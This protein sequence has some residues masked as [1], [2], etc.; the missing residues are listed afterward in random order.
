MAGACT[1]G[2]APSCDDG[3]VCNGAE[4]CNPVDGTCLAGAPISC[5]VL[6]NNGLAPPIAS[7]L[8]DHVDYNEASGQLVYVRS[9]GC[10]PFGG[11]DS[12][13]CPIP[14]VPTTL[15]VAVGGD[16]GD[17]DVF[18]TALLQ[19]TGGS[20]Q[21]LASGQNAWVDLLGGA[22]ASAESYG[23]T[24]VA[25]G[26]HGFLR[27]LG[28]ATVTGG[29]IQNLLLDSD[30]ISP[31]GAVWGG[32]V[33]TLFSG[34]ASSVRGGR[35]SVLCAVEDPGTVYGSQ[36]NLNAGMYGPFP[37]ATGFVSGTLESGD[38]LNATYHQTGS[39]CY[40]PEDG[41]FDT[42]GTFTLLPPEST[43]VA[44]GQ[45][46]PD[47]Q[48]V[49]DEDDAATQFH[50]V[51]VRN[52][53]CPDL[54]PSAYPDD[55]C[56]LPG[57]ATSVE[58]VGGAVIP[59][60]F[61]V[62]DTSTAIIRGGQVAELRMSAGASI[63]IWGNEFTIG[64]VPVPFG[65][66]LDESGVL[67][68]TLATG[69][70]IVASFDRE[71]P[72]VMGTYGVIVLR[73]AS[74]LVSG[75]NVVGTLFGGLGSIG[76][77]EVD[78]HVENGGILIGEYESIALADIN[79]QIPDFI[80]LATPARGF[81]DQYQIWELEFSGTLLDVGHSKA[82][83]AYDPALV[84]EGQQLII[85]AWDGAQWVRMKDGVVIDSINHTISIV[86]DSF[87]IFALIIREFM[88]PVLSVFGMLSLAGG[89]AVS[90]L[91]ARNRS[92]VGG[93]A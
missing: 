46:F 30:F 92:R 44:N 73:S 67:V 19:V 4:T 49:F 42:S 57:I 24:F 52:E 8:I 66:V 89:L 16:L 20:V 34:T 47:P 72:L 7:N 80:G 62:L 88:V 29:S 31:G 76:G 41:V 14:G 33:E 90:G 36:F 12:S 2:P 37:G 22:V 39:W 3:D 63:E 87:T 43:F 13:P 38:L 81:E 40:H 61:S 79:Q 64:G 54:W 1:N 10:P 53:S 48:N 69:E 75:N 35:V 50:D 74:E 17:V 26:D 9:Q 5:E 71:D 78:L 77:V 21:K 32:K 55:P 82:T 51:F 23:T 91:I 68:G 56:T 60:V 27:L 15:E 65:E 6:V 84:Q 85:F 83:F 18:D 25:G 93:G 28:Q 70:P 11:V 45:S 58:V 59:G 86:I